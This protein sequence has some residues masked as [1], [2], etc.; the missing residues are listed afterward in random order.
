MPLH[1]T[2][3]NLWALLVAGAA[4]YVLGAVWYGVFG[5]TWLRLSGKTLEEVKKNASP[6]PYVIAAITSVI[7]A[8]A[9][10]YMLRISGADA[11]LAGALQFGMIV[12]L[13]FGI[14][15]AA[16]HYAFSGWSAKLLLLDY[17][18]DLV[19]ILAMCAILAMWK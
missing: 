17:A 19:S 5:K 3:L 9:L 14:C 6:M 7:T 2:H 4:Y 1:Y 8:A 15:I 12:W 18:Y 13:G 11:S 16:K 10:A